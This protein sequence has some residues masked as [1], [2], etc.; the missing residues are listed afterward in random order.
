L[1]APPEPSVAPFPGAG[2]LFDEQAVPKTVSTATI[3]QTERV[4]TMSDSLLAEIRDTPSKWV[5]W[6][7]ECLTA[8]GAKSRDKWRQPRL[9][10]SAPE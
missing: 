3:E 7:R 2:E 10:V 1:D 5:F 6:T 9:G 8:T 4:D